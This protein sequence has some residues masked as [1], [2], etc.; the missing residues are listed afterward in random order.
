VGQEA[1][2]DVAKYVG[3]GEVRGD[4]R[5]SVGGGK[6]VSI[7]LLQ[8]KSTPTRATLTTTTPYRPQFLTDMAIPITR[9]N[10]RRGNL[11]RFVL[12]I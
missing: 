11:Q 2:D 8:P 9:T 7:E 4:T 1:A 6:A 5:D 12:C 10:H 3:R